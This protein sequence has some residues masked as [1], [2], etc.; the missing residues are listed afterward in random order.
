MMSVVVYLAMA[1]SHQRVMREVFSI[2]QV[3]SRFFI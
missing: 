3:S 1:M 2:D